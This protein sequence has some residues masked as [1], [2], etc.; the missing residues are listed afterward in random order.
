MQTTFLPQQSY[1]REGESCQCLAWHPSSHETHT[2]KWRTTKMCPN[3]SAVGKHTD[4][5]AILLHII[6]AP[7]CFS[8]T[9]NSFKCLGK[10]C[11]LHV[12]VFR[13]TLHWGLHG[14]LS[15]QKHPLNLERD[16]CM[17]MM[18]K[19]K[20]QVTLRTIFLSILSNSP[21]LSKCMYYLVNTKGLIFSVCFLTSS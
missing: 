10:Y 6:T 17:Y 18:T 19:N 2:D 12:P 20:H 5:G 15:Y 13:D 8:F 1:L 16:F 3:H 21:L 14:T 4:L 9:V 7:T 11:S